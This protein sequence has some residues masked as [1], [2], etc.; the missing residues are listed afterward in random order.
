MMS[1]MCYSTR[2]DDGELTKVTKNAKMS[3]IASAKAAL[4]I[5]HVLLVETLM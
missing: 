2:A 4:S 1:A 3:M 5:A